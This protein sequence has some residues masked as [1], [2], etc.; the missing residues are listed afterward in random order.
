MP[1]TDEGEAKQCQRIV[2]GKL[3]EGWEISLFTD[4]DVIGAD[5]GEAFAGVSELEGVVGIVWKGNNETA[6]GGVETFHAAESPAFLVA[7]GAWGE[8]QKSVNFGNGFGQRSGIVVEGGNGEDGFEAWVGGMDGGIGFG[9]FGPKGFFFGVCGG[10]EFE[11]VKPFVVFAGGFEMGND[12]GDQFGGDAWMAGVGKFLDQFEEEIGLVG[13]LLGEF[14]PAELGVIQLSLGEQGT[15][16][17][18]MFVGGRHAG[19][20]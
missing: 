4:F 11:G 1:V 17:L 10:A 16:L 7:I 2:G 8:G 14:Q 12:Q 20:L 9:E 18:V 6:E 15:E 3:L 5:G 13:K 19:G